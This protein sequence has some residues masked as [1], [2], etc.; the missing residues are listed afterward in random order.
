MNEN[1]KVR[2]FL[3]RSSINQKCKKKVCT[4]TI[5]VKSNWY[6]IEKMNLI[7][8]NIQLLLF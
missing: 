3:N 1:Q 6:S 2:R 7:Y 4:S 5:V 8:L